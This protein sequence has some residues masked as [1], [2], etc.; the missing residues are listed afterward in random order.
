MA[1][2]IHILK[3]ESRFFWPVFDGV[4]TWELRNNDR[5]YQAGEFLWLRDWNGKAYTGSSV[6]VKILDVSIG[7]MEKF[8]DC[9]QSAYV[10][11]SIQLWTKIDERLPE[12]ISQTSLDL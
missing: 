3:S 1:D 12:E 2:K 11:L 4:K 7:V 5:N 9:Q 6:I 10:L 8:L